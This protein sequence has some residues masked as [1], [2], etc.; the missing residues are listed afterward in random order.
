MKRLK[1]IWWILTKKYVSV[2]W[3]GGDEVRYETDY[4]TTAPSN[5]AANM[6]CWMCMYAKC[7]KYHKEQIP[8]LVCKNFEY[9][10]GESK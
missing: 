2:C 4:D 10:D 8:V 6:A 7:E 3:R 1:M 9:Y 5:L